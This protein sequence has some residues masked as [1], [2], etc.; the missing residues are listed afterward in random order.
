MDP[1]HRELKGRP[2][3]S[4]QTMLGMLKGEYGDVVSGGYTVL[5]ARW[6]DEYE[7]GHIEGAIHASSKETVRDALW[8]PNGCPKYGPQHVDRRLHLSISRPVTQLMYVKK[9]KAAELPTQQDFDGNT[10]LHTAAHFNNT[11]SVEQ[12]L[13]WGQEQDLPLLRISNHEGKTPWDCALGH[14]RIRQL[15]R[16]YR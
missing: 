3:I 12:L 13:K 16:K 11:A 14:P 7:G 10:A 9:G 15:M 5:D 6:T 2:R 8:D 1:D 4:P